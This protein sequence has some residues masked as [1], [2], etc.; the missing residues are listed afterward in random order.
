MQRY[1]LEVEGIPEYINM[2]KNAQKK[3]GRYS[4]MIANET[5]LLFASTA[6]LTTEIFTRTNNDWEDRAEAGKLSPNGRQRTRER[7]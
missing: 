3:A 7:T 4:C 6:M 2:L 1:Q 5:L